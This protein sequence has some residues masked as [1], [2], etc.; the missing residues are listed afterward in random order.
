MQICKNAKIQKDEINKIIINQNIE[1]LIKTRL[2]YDQNRCYNR[3][4]MM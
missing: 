3:L 2:Q 1:N 4:E